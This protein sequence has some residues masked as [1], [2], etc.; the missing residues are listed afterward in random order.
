MDLSKISIGLKTFIRDPQLFDA[1]DG[2]RTI[3]PEVQIIVADCG[4][5]TEEKDSL[6]AEMVRQG[7]KTIL[8]DF[9]AGFGRM[10]NAIADA[11]ERPYLLIGSDDFD[12]RPL[13]VR[14]GI[15]ELLAV[16]ENNPEISVAAGRVN[17]KVY[18]FN[19]IDN[20]AE[21]LEVPLHQD[22]VPFLWFRRVDLAVNYV[23]VRRSV[24]SQIRWDDTLIGQGE[25]LAWYLDLKRA[26]FKVVW[27]RG[28]NINEQ[29][30]PNTERYRTYRNRALSPERLCYVKR[31]IKRV[32][33]GSGYIDYE[34]KI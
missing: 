34:E 18:E 14:R 29:K 11:L 31:G 26:G 27:V 22:N 17:N 21:V 4:E 15:E 30:L 5:H 28:V 13:D 16:L 8:L 19:L 12:F 33:L 1:I 32:V 7:H 24:F 10:S 25:H 9:D 20:G 6:Y 23:L 3:M 2:I